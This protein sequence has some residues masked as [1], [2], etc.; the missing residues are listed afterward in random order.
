MEW[1]VEDT[2]FDYKTLV[3]EIL[4]ESDQDVKFIVL[5]L[6]PAVSVAKLRAEIIAVDWLAYVMHLSK[7]LEL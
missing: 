4:L 3:D 7:A 6:D 5:F 2:G 1:V